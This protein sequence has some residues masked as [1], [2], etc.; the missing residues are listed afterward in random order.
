M[1]SAIGKHAPRGYTLLE[2]VVT[3]ALLAGLTLT[4]PLARD[5][6]QPQYR[7]DL[8]AT[9]LTSDLRGL[10]AQAE[11]SGHTTVFRALPDQHGYR[12]DSRARTVHWPAD[13]RLSSPRNHVSSALQADGDLHLEFYPDG[14]SSGADLLIS[15]GSNALHLRVSP[16]SGRISRP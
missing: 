9:R 4:F 10:R 6:L 13:I 2:L 14:S 11:R 8:L 5:R 1:T 7:L 15:R 3:L 16:L 12:L